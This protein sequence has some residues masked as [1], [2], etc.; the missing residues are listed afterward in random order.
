MK[1]STAFVLARG[2]ESKIFKDKFSFLLD[3]LSKGYPFLLS[4]F[5]VMFERHTEQVGSKPVKSQL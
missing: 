2:C 3:S 1:V 4:I 5:T